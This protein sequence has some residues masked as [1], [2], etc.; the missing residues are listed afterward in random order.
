MRRIALTIVLASAVAATPALAENTT[1]PGGTSLSVTID[2][3]ANGAVLGS[4]FAVSGTAA[5]GA[6]TPVKDTSLVYAVDVSGSANDP[7]GVNCDGVG[8]NDS[9]LTCEKAAVNR[10][11][12]EAALT[13]SPIADSGVVRFNNTATAL[14]V[15]PAAGVQLLTGP[16]PNI[17]NAVTP[18]TAGGGTSFV[19]ALNA[20]NQVLGVSQQPV[21]IL[22]FLSDGVDTAGGTLPSFPDPDDTIV[23]AFAI[24]GAGCGGGNPSL[25]AVAAKG[26]AGS[27]CQ[28]VTDLSQ[29]DD[30]ISDAIG[31]TLD[32]LTLT[33]D[34]GGP[35]SIDAGL[36]QTGPATVNFSTSVSG[37]SV[38]MHE[39]CVTATGTDAGGS[40][41]VT[42]C[43]NVQV[44]AS[45]A[46]T[47]NTPCQL[48]VNDANVAVANFRGV[49]LGT[50]NEPK[51]VAMRAAGRGLVECGGQACVT[52]FDVLFDG[53]GGQGVAEL[54]VIAGKQFSTPPGQAAVFIDGVEVVA[55]CKNNGTPLPCQKINRTGT[56]QTQYFVRFAA[57]PGI[58]FR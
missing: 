58:R 19:A 36:P 39:I 30:V 29:L 57:D 6:G 12:T 3:P 32:S 53:T 20:A 17:T 45:V 1:L 8:G 35:I 9:V 31:A 56:G 27:S 5:V 33:V 18:L 24:G 14:D 38:G 51:V 50:P 41:S 34:D 4:T 22:V 13:T 54:T 10:V 23:F 16:G 7:S 25:N 52:G 28:V 42:D 44:I 46:C 15:D 40:D 43:N 21:K 47:P 2:S 26:A 37:L 48:T 55:K 11:N 49:G